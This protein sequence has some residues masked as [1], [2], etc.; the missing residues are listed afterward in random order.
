VAAAAV[1][2]GAAAAAAV[3]VAAAAEALGKGFPALSAMAVRLHR[4][5]GRISASLG[6]TRFSLMCSDKH[7]RGSQPVYIRGL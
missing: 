5:G 3:R 2:D 6:V 1:A 4:S 7:A